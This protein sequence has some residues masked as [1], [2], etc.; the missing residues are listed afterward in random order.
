M[1]FEDLFQIFDHLRRQNLVRVE[2][3]GLG[4]AFHLFGLAHLGVTVVAA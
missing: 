1:E 3:V 4:L 2:V